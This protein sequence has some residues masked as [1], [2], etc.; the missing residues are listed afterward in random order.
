MSYLLKL[1]LSFPIGGLVTV[2][3]PTINPQGCRL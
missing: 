1:I 2:K 3:G